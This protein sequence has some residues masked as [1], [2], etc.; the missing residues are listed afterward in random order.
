MLHDLARDHRDP[1]TCPILGQSPMV[2][3]WGPDG[4]KAVFGAD[5]SA[6]AP[7]TSDA[8]AV[9][10][11]RGSL[12]LQAG[13]AHKRARKLLSPPFHGERMRTYAELMQATAVR[14][15]ERVQPGVS[16]PFLE[17]AQ[18]I[19]LDV[20]IAAIFGVQDPARV[21]RLHDEILGIV[22]S[23][24]PLIAAFRFLQRDFGGFGPWAKFRRKADALQ[25]TMRALMDE[26]RK[27]PGEDV[28]S[29]LLAARDEAGEALGEQEVIE[30]LLTFVVAGHETTATTLAWALYELHRHP[31][32]LAKLRDELAASAGGPPEALHRLP[33]LAAV[34]NETLRMHPPVPI[35]P[36]RCAR[37]FSLLGYELP[38]GQTVGVAILLAHHDAQ[39]F[40]DPF[41]FRP[42][43]FLEKTYSPFEFMPWGGGARRCLGASFAT[44]ELQIVLGT[45]LSRARFSLDE[46]SP[47]RATFRIG[48]Y[49]PET[50]IRLTR[51]AP[52]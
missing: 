9:I 42:E 44:W 40:A 34:V 28:L 13:D 45:I 8:L 37:E 38:A 3:T 5:P 39:T 43:R 6:F 33:Y 27:A 4:A 19:T 23:F 2:L 35:V 20:I 50:G 21:A 22:A 49:G 24:N 16:A 11:G 25:G 12:F 46:P 7:G 10:V 14:W 17:T 26:K 15:L 32:A 31:P 30:Q 18:G 48:T 41:A 51:L 1:L 36:R 47:V 29:L 52:T